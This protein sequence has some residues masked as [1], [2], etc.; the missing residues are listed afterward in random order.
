MQNPAL[1]PTQKFPLIT[2][3]KKPSTLAIS[4]Y[5]VPRFDLSTALNSVLTLNPEPLPPKANQTI[6]LYTHIE[7]LAHYDHVPIAYMNRTSWKSQSPP[8]LTLP[9]SQ[10]NEHQFVPDIVGN[11]GWVDIVVNNLDKD[12]GHPFHLVSP[13]FFAFYFITLKLSPSIQS[14]ISS[15]TAFSLLS[16]NYQT[17]RP[18]FLHPNPPRI[19]PTLRIQNIQPIRPPLRCSNCISSPESNKPTIERHGSYP[20]TRICYL[21]DQSG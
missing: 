15:L 3:S 7:M 6:L 8:L 21:E 14:Y 4:Q 20:E 5:P 12:A 16:S 19:F 10:W 11:G 13:T 17:A 1:T 18:R 9:A 2:S